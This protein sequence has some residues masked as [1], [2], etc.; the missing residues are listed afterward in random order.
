H[1]SLHDAAATELSAE[2]EAAA[3]R[4][5]E[6]ADRC[7]RGALDIDPTAS[8]AALGL[9]RS[10][11]AR[12]EHVEVVKL[13]D[14]HVKK[15]PPPRDDDASLRRAQVYE[16][17]A[18]AHEAIGS[19]GRA[20]EALERRLK[21]AEDTA[22]RVRLAELYNAEPGRDEAAL[23]NHRVL[24]RDLS[25]TDSL[26]A[27]SHAAREA[28]APY[29]AYCIDRV[30]EALGELDEQ[31][32]A[33]L[34]QQRPAALPPHAPYGGEISDADREGL[35][36]GDDL[37]LMGEVFA[38]LWG[39]A[40]TLLPKDLESHG[41]TSKDRVSPAGKEPLALVYS[42]AARALGIKSTAVYVGEGDPLDPVR[43][44]AMAPPAVIVPRGV[45]EHC[46]VDELRFRVGRALELTQPAYVMAE[47]MPRERFAEILRLVLHAFHP[48][49]LRKRPRPTER[50][51]ALREEAQ[52]FRRALPYKIARSLGEL[53][54]ERADA[55]FDSG[56]WRKAVDHAATRVGLILSGDLAVALD[57]VRRREPELAE[58][59][60]RAQVAS[61]EAVSDLLTF[62]AS[63]SY[64]ICRVKLGLGGNG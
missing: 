43:V 33:Q 11:E 5:F 42:A 4:H 36:T 52:Q 14:A 6:A 10:F 12:G 46:S 50:E 37:K 41:V 57:W 27:L 18:R 47:G 21:L 64:Y 61:S 60:P 48:R 53:L 59:E 24:A 19:V 8:E 51:M 30:L 58:L 63:D 62:A 2:D 25:R 35:L 38:T 40:P 49:Y 44:I 22:T 28:S 39:A 3:G 17:L 29:R 32:S 20:I 55:S 1:L 56:A 34:E 13:L 16:L 26:R 54:R 45:A 31:A 23:A 7:R 15:L 9:A